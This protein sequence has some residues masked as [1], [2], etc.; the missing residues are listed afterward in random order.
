MQC[1]A[2]PSGLRRHS[3]YESRGELFSEDLERVEGAAGGEVVDLVAAGC[4]GRY[5]QRLRSCRKRRQ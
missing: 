2:N 3:L 1:P 4:A 5:D